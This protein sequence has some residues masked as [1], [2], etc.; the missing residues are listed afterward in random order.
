MIYQLDQCTSNLLSHLVSASAPI[1]AT[2]ACPPSVFPFYG[3]TP[4][5][6]RA[7]SN[8]ATIQVRALPVPAAACCL[9]MQLCCVPALHTAPAH[10]LRQACPSTGAKQPCGGLQSPPFPPSLSPPA[11]QREGHHQCHVAPAAPRGATAPSSHERRCAD[12]PAWT[13]DIWPGL[14]GLPLH[15]G[16]LVHLSLGC[17]QGPQRSR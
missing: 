12:L 7:M 1:L 14:Q 15:T 5:M 8:P 2:Q 10:R 11:G 6:L 9:L 16:T 13:G 17:L 3:L 4:A